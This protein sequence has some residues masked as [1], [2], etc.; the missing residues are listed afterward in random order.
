[1][2]CRLGQFLPLLPP[3]YVAVSSLSPIPG[4]VTPKL[5]HNDHAKQLN[6]RHHHHHPPKL[7]P[8]PYPV[9]LSLEAYTKP[10]LC[11]PGRAEGGACKS[12]ACISAT[13]RPHQATTTSSPQ[14]TL[15]TPHPNRRCVPPSPGTLPPN[16]ASRGFQMA[17]NLFDLS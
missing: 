13:G 16:S 7:L 8:C 14:S 9:L 2:T 11:K 4:T 17:N 10:I 5:S 3:F 12:M 15:H 1:M 6:K